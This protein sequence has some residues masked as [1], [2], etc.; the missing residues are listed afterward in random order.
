MAQYVTIPVTSSEGTTIPLMNH[1][2]QQPEAGLAICRPWKEMSGE[3]PGLTHGV[4][5]IV[6]CIFNVPVLSSQQITGGFPPFNSSQHAALLMGAIV[7][8]IHAFFRNTD[9]LFLDEEAAEKA[10]LITRSS[11]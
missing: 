5:G 1:A 4:R 9:D 3:P 11:S 7:V 8:E 2:K 6:V 10:G